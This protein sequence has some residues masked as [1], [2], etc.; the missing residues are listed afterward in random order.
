MGALGADAFD[1][2]VHRFGLETVGECDCG[3]WDILEAE[4]LVADFAVE[5]YVTVIIYV[6][7]S[8][9]EF[10]SDP[11]AAVVNLMQQMVVAEQCQ[12]AEYPGLID[13]VDLVLQLGHSDGVVDIGQRFKHQQPIGCGLDTV[14]V[15]NLFQILHIHCEVTQ[16]KV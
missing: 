10:V 16:K 15:Q 12:S 3:N 13:G 14:L 1:H 5:M 4:G 2:I 11:F 8:V 9:A 7:V 6:A